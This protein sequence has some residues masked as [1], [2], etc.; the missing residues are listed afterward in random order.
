M[1]HNCN[2][3]LPPGFYKYKQKQP[4]NETMYF[5]TY[6]T[7]QVMHKLYVNSDVIDLACEAYSSVTLVMFE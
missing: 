1:Q 7:R 6:T 3:E 4:V 5:T 2:Q